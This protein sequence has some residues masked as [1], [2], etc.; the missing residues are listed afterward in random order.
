MTRTG[1]SP[2]DR[3]GVVRAGITVMALLGPVV[4]GA[5]L[6]P[7][8]DAGSHRWQP[9]Q[10]RVEDGSL[11]ARLPA[12]RTGIHFTNSVPI[13]AAMANNNLL[14]GAGVALGDVDGDGR[15]DI[16]LCN[17]G[18]PNAL[19]RNLGG[20]RF[21]PVPDTAGAALADQASTGAV[22]ADLDG[23][24]HLDLVVT[25]MT[26]GPSLFL[27]DGKGGF[28]RA[29]NPGFHAHG[30]GSSIAVADL[31]DDGLPD[32]YMA[33]YAD[34]SIL[35]SGGAIPMRLVDGEM[36]PS[37]PLA[38]R[39]RI[40]DGRMVEMGD[41]DH[42]YLNRGNGRFEDLSWTGGRFLDEQ[43]K[44][45]LETPMEL[46]LSVI[47]R[48]ING[49]GR[50][51]IYVCNDFDFP[52][53]I[54][55]N[56][57][58]A[59]FRALPTTAL[60]KTSHFSMAVDVADID[61]DGLDDLFVVDMAS[62]THRLR[63]TQS[64]DFN[65][66]PRLPG[67][68]LDRPLASHNTLHIN[69]GDGSWLEVAHAA[70]VAASEWS[71]STAFLDVDLDGFEDILVGTGHAFDILDLDAMERIMARRRRGPTGMRQA[72]E[73]LLLFPP[74][75]VPNHAFHNRGDGTFAER[76]A[77]W[78]FDA[79][80]VSHGM[81][82]A[83]LDDDGDLDV[84]INC[85]NAPPLVY[86]NNADAPRVAV[87]LSGR[88]PNTQGIGSRLRLLGGPVVQSQ[89]VVSGGRYLS[90]DD[91]VR[92][93]A[94]G[95]GSAR[96]LTLEVTWPDGRHQLLAGIRP[97]TRVVVHPPEPPADAPPPVRDDPPPLFADES[98]LLG[99]VHAEPPFNDF[100][101]QPLL[102]RRLSQG[103]PGLAWVDLDADGWDD[104]VIG[105]GRGGAPVLLRNVGGRSFERL[106]QPA[107]AIP[108][109]LTG[110]VSLPAR[111]GSERP[112]R[113]IAGLAGLETD[114]PGGG[115]LLGLGPDASH[116]PET[117]PTLPA[118]PG[119]LAVADV[120]R[121]GRLDLFVGGQFLRGRHPEPAS[122][123]LLLGQDDGSFL[124]DEANRP[125]LSG[126]GLVNGAIWSDLDADGW[127]DLVLACEWGPVRVLHNREGRLVD[128]TAEWDL[129]RHAGWWQGVATG[130]F[131]GDGL[132]DL[133]ASNW[134]RNSPYQAS[135]DAPVHLFHSD[136]DGSGSVDHIESLTDPATGRLLPRRN[137]FVLGA[138]FPFLRQAYPTHASFAGTDIP[139]LLRNRFATAGHLQATTLESSVFLNRGSRFERH[140]L[141]REAQ[142]AP[143]FG[144]AVA[145]F[146][147]DGN[148]DIALAQNFFGTPPDHPR[149]D[150]GVG[151]I[152]LGRGDGTFDRLR[153][154]GSGIRVLGE[155]RGLAVADFNGDGRPDIAIG[156][157]GA[158]TRLFRNT[159]ARPGI[160]IR[161]EGPPGN[162]S[163][164]GTR[165]QLLGA[166][167]SRSPLREVQAGG[168]YWSQ[169]ALAP[170]LQIRS[171][172][173]AVRVLR[174]GLPE[175]VVPV[176]E[177]AREVR[178]P[179]P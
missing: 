6:P 27:N 144:V 61:R 106:P 47:L 82:L 28:S 85:L 139:G 93:F 3:T 91:P 123:T 172:A 42:L 137:L 26:T 40:V 41:P 22:L 175:Q 112:V 132:T 143:A 176:P 121:D 18:G 38:R 57:G 4:L 66:P 120:N 138:V 13:A 154:A 86:R 55:I 43:G 51:D 155:Q 130:D 80:E 36:Q 151:R 49:D 30:G 118:S 1:A 177:G 77:D 160:R 111:T 162:P 173:V 142:W 133:V 53:R 71:W 158:E 97:N 109:D 19:Y 129:I 161:L 165:L 89:T 95:P 114:D 159:R 116:P 63:M 68:H 150:G 69:Q 74:L 62:R 11:L 64:G 10:P 48:D 92:V 127:P 128:G 136:L 96:D 145:D 134:G 98:P 157:N 179:L 104:L 102:P 117:L 20:F 170:V 46:G 113:I 21:E 153:A 166:D 52:D 100:L 24:G 124:P 9:L 146:D 33:S 29:D 90:G 119:P 25:S 78:G 65:P 131:D 126:I 168:G 15:V 156:Q 135:V 23:D 103:G 149:L 44:P 174:P 59:H 140:P 32:L 84:V 73:D 99:H 147:G 12:D 141:P 60:R 67:V 45:L 115:S 54:W 37:G 7:W 81:A 14:N 58:N 50:P 2:L 34:L 31:N 72:R 56:Q 35:R 88:A 83:D 87:R 17:L 101:R 8:T 107:M 178:V 125:V 79:P 16:Y 39:L 70:G 122:S 108:D 167:G 169:N 110:I 75:I 76:G 163:A 94:A 148:E 152:L 5:G 171:P 105:S 164:I